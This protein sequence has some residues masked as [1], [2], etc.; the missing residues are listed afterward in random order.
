MPRYAAR[1][2]LKQRSLFH[3]KFP[4]RRAWGS[5]LGAGCTAAPRWNGQCRRRRSHPQLGMYTLKGITPAPPN[6]SS[7]SMTFVE[8]RQDGEATRAF[9]RLP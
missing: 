2:P 3:P 6:R 4:V 7:I 5:K 8:Q 1:H 9:S